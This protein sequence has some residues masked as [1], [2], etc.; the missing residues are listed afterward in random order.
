YSRT[1]F[2]VHRKTPWSV[3]RTA[4]ALHH[5]LQKRRQFHK[6]S[7]QRAE[8]PHSERSPALFGTHPTGRKS[9]TPILRKRCLSPKNSGRTGRKKCRLRALRSADHRAWDKEDHTSVPAAVSMKCTTVRNHQGTGPTRSDR[10]TI[11]QTRNV[12]NMRTE[13]PSTHTSG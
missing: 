1:V 10:E 3:P 11:G 9:S 5:P 13:R 4:I 12:D 2:A 6:T 8:V 7:G